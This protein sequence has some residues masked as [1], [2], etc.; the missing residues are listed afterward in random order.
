MRDGPSMACQVMRQR[1]GGC[2]EGGNGSNGPCIK[3]ILIRAACGMGATSDGGVVTVVCV[4]CC[5]GLLSVFFR[6]MG[7]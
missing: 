5:K 4:L 1:R 2:S 3:C 7:N 6:E